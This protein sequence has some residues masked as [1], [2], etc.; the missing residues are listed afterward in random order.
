MQN[1]L[2]LNPVVV[3]SPNTTIVVLGLPPTLHHGAATN[4]T[5]KAAGTLVLCV[6]VMIYTGHAGDAQFPAAG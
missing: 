3:R 4:R 6:V 1:E 2:I 5:K